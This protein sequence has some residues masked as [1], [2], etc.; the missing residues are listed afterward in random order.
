MNTVV[1][2]KLP[3]IPGSPGV[4]LMKDA[5]GRVIY[6]G[7]AANLKSRLS[8]YAVSAPHPDAK[9][10]VLVEK[11][12][13]IETIVTATVQEALILEANL[14][15]RHKPPYNVILKDDK[16]YPSLRLDIT[17]PYPCLQLVR[18]TQRDG[19]LYFGP[20]ASATALR[21][22]VKLI[23]KT[24][25]LRK[26]RTP[27]VR[28]RP[29]P[30]LNH[31]MELCLAPCSLPVDP[32][33]YNDMV[34]EVRMFLSGRTRVLMDKIKAEMQAAAQRQEFEQAARFR[35]KLFAVQQVIEKQ[36]VVTNDFLDRDVVG[37]A[38]DNGR[39][40]VAVMFI[41][42]GR[43]LGVRQYPVREA[44][45]GDA[46]II[47][48]FF[49]HYYVQTHDIP[50][51]ILVPIPLADAGLYAQWLS[52]LKTRKVGILTPQRGYR[53]RLLKMAAEN[54]A[55]RLKAFIDFEN[56][57]KAA[58]ESVQH[59]LK[60]TRYPRRI[61]CFDNSGISGKHL[62][63]GRAVFINGRPDPALHRRYLIRTVTDVQDDYACMKEVLSRRFHKSR[64]SEEM[65]DLLMV[66]GGKG[67][68]HI[69]VSVLDEFGLD[70][71]IDV[72]GIAKGEGTEG[73][74][75]DKI[76][77]PGR[78]NPLNL[79]RQADV[80]GFL[81]GIRDEAHRLAVTFHRKTR[82]RSTLRSRLDFVSGIGPKR[83]AALLKTFGGI[84][85]ICRASID[86]LAAL[87]GMNR[88]IASRVLAAL[89][90]T[91]K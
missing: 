86:E 38:R 5:G 90:L 54:A 37:I 40:M 2:E 36:D 1:A 63:A 52:G 71:E 79:T 87:P 35:D 91:D 6:V 74:G 26:C 45:S 18:K 34:D 31:Q 47:D 53:I 49:R 39:A 42:D 4:Y 16:R 77:K 55:L 44:L 78:A 3:D 28:K 9:T 24:F 23:N 80:R 21:Q 50:E 19:A 27:E 20:Y 75:Q 81:A 83:K 61:E 84:D 76:Y 65:P 7:K 13:D 64:S 32:S 46:E 62:V 73:A 59:H 88:K 25:K 8:S 68:L 51:E 58:L 66:D 15:R 72:V 41:R 48:A 14:I 82:N 33:V 85:G 12:A 43:L 67:Q 29:R 57:G 22:T 30:C 17:S 56:T 60:L 10:A 69:A 89:S 11:I 70:Q